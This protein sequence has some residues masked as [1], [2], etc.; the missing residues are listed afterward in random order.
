MPRMMP[1]M[2]LAPLAPLV[3]SL[4]IVVFALALAPACAHRP[5]IVPT[6]TA[7]PLEAS[8]VARLLP[9]KVKDRDGWAD[10]VIAAI[11]L[12]KKEP[13][14]E[15]VC[16]VLA[17]IEQESGY[18]AD[19][20]VADLPRIVR[21]GLEEKLAPLGPLAGP[22]L[23]ALL[24]LQA[25]GSAQSFGARIARLRTERDLDRLFRDIRDATRDKMPGPFGVG[26]ALSA[27][28]GKGTLDDLNPVTTAGSMQVKVSFAKELGEREGLD[29]DDVR[30]LLYTR[31]GGVRFGTAR[32]IGYPASY[33][34]I[35]HRFADYNAGVYASR[36]AM[37]QTMLAALTGRPLVPD[38]DLLAW[39]DDG[40]PQDVVTHSLA[41]LLAFGEARGLSAWSVKRDAK[42]EKSVDFEDTKLW[43][44]VRAAW[45]E[46][47]GQAAPYARVPD[48]ALVSP[49]LSK[50]RTT[51]WFAA[52]VKRRYDACRAK[53][54]ASQPSARAASPSP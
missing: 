13:T 8:E 31:G 42:K 46:K 21:R 37:F 3:P 41:A 54:P 6:P 38:G 20:I 52:S 19:P 50:P 34:D 47:T 45:E 32:L 1:R 30:E 29:D 43:K 25:P 15:R 49:K 12:T 27:L 5:E 53:V 17:V 22:A 26:E 11:R 24:E 14:A 28:L 40:D 33:A 16:A 9:A 36:N 48:V 7:P 10:D 51:A 2:R 44:E 4:L 18:Q 23:D 39:D 35:T